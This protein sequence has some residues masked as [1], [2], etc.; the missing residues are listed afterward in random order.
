MA[1]RLPQA[2]RQTISGAGHIVNIEASAA[3]NEAA[4]RFIRKIASHRSD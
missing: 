1:A 2:E 4:T 3:F